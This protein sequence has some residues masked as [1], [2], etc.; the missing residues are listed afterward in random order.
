[1]RKINLCEVLKPSVGMGK[2][3]AI[4][5]NGALKQISRG[6]FDVIEDHVETEIEL[7]GERLIVVVDNNI[8][9]YDFRN[10]VYIADKK[11]PSL[12][13]LYEKT[14]TGENID[15]VEMLRKYRE[16]HLLSGAALAEEVWFK[17]YHIKDPKDSYRDHYG[18]KWIDYEKQLAKGNIIYDPSN[19]NGLWAM[20]ADMMIRCMNEECFERYGNH[21]LVVRPTPDDAYLLDGKEIIGPR[22]VVE[23][24]L[25]LTNADD[26][27][28][29]FRC[30]DEI[31][32]KSAE[33]EKEEIRAEL[34]KEIQEKVDTIDQLVFVDRLATKFKRQ[35]LI[36]SLLGIAIGI[37]IGII[38]G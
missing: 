23:K 33:R 3:A 22:Y 15:L 14:A 26:L 11:E 25:N 27:G 18:A 7:N 24:K 13:Y 10:R 1:M 6:R 35:R 37:A 28:K 38:I 8:S 19:L 21:L 34:R 36:W 12:D 16:D 17:L 30:L 4:I 9:L 2:D 20:P 32:K 5:E 29:L 31:K